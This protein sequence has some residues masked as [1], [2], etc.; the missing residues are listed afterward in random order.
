MNKVR[1]TMTLH[2]KTVSEYQKHITTK[3]VRSA[4]NR[5]RKIQ[6]DQRVWVTA[7]KLAKRDV[8]RLKVISPT[9]V[10]VLNASKR[11]A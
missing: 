11:K 4:Q 2:H 9:E 7:M 8:T 5:V 6:V 1:D 3:T 10:I